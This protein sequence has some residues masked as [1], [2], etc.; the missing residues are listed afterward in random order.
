MTIAKLSS[1]PEKTHSSPGGKYRGTRQSISGALGGIKDVGTWGGGHPFD[2]EQIR[3][4]SGAT[5]FPYHA[6]AAQ[7]EMYVF[8]AGRGEVRGPDGTAAV[9]AGDS[10][11]FRPGEAHQLRNTGD[12]DLVYLVI[13]DHPMA[14]VINYPD[15]PGKWV[16]KPDPK[17]FTMNEASYFEPGE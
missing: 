13:A 2:V 5:S 1:I 17:C 7:W 11:I 12:A 6:H 14:D 8:T 16:V 4:P 9:E 10:I 15:T 3:I